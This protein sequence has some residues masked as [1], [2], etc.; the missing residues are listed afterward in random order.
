[1]KKLFLLLFVPG[2]CFPQQWAKKLPF[3]ATFAQQKEAFYNYYKNVP[4]GWLSDDDYAH[5]KRRERIMEE[6]EKH[7]PGVNPNNELMKAYL[8]MQNPSIAIGAKNKTTQTAA[9]NWQPMGPFGPMTYAIGDGRL[10]SVKVDPTNNNIVWV[11]SGNGGL[12]KSTT[13]G[14]SWTFMSNGMPDLGVAD[15]AIDPTNTNNMYISTGDHFGGGGYSLG[16][17]KSTNGG[18]TWAQ[19]SLSYSMTQTKNCNKILIDNANPNKIFVATTDG[20]WRSLN[21][22]STWS[23]VKPGTI[24]DI[25][26]NTANTN[27]LYA[28]SD[29][30]YTSVNGGTTWKSIPGAPTY[31]LNWG[32]RSL[33]ATTAA[34]PNTIF[35]MDETYKVYKSVNAG[36]SWTN[37]FSTAL[38]YGAYDM[39]IGI[40]PLN[41]SEIYIFGG[42]Y[43]KSLDAG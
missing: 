29:S 7:P 35:L 8:Q 36:T 4:Q 32:S 39:G 38:G 18:V 16:V 26:F 41:A 33:L 5:F 42:A 13:G 11:G 3:N 28:S 10:I 12:W 1:M 17:F 23:L 27:T 25:Q 24:F 19:T 43:Y 22:G 15:I 30:I 40:S 31:T 2:F 14:G 9:A 6:F 34:D 37:V 20:I 21:A